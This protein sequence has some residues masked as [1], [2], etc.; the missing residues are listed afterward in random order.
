MRGRYKKLIAKLPK[1]GWHCKVEGYD[2]RR[3]TREELEEAVS[4]YLE[5]YDIEGDAA[6]IVEKAFC[7]ENPSLCRWGDE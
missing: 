1:N 2:F 5:R 4:E 7:D 6:R 3:D